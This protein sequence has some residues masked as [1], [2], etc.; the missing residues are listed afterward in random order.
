MGLV[1]HKSHKCG[2]FPLDRTIQNSRTFCG[3]LSKCSAYYI[4]NVTVSGLNPEN[5]VQ[6][7]ILFFIYE[8]KLI[9]HY[10]PPMNPLTY[11]YNWVI[12]KL[13]SPLELNVDVFH[14]M[15]AFIEK[16]PHQTL[17]K[18]PL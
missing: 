8:K 2:F 6:I 1:T 3:F 14:S 17:V 15:F 13:S 10:N 5:K 11:E 16:F 4:L 7:V 9:S 12:L 18:F